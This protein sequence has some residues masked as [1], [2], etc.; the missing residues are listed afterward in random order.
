MTVLSAQSIRDLCVPREHRLYSWAPPPPAPVWL[1]YVTRRVDHPLIDPF[2]ER[3]VVSGRTVGLGPCSYDVRSRA[4][5]VLPVRAC[6]LAS[7]VEHFCLPYW[8]C[9]TVLDKSSHAR[10]FV[11]AFNT[12][13]EPGWRGHLTVELVNL[14]DRPVRW[15]AGDPLCHVRFELLDAPTSLPYRGKY[16]DQPDHPVGPIEEAS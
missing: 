13:L 2:V 16:Q 10:V 14:G 15:A 8:L 5:V 1:S 6:V 11:S 9:G 3:S 12:Q 7:T 4:D